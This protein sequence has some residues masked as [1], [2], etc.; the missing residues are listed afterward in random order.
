M[1]ADRQIDEEVL[2]EE[3]WGPLDEQDDETL[4][5]IAEW[6]EEQPGPRKKQPVRTNVQEQMV[7]EARAAGQRASQSQADPVRARGLLY[8]KQTGRYTITVEEENT[9]RTGKKLLVV[10]ALVGNAVYSR[11]RHI[12]DVS[13]VDGKAKQLAFYMIEK[14][15]A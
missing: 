11:E 2:A 13:A 8:E 12:V 3:G 14:V 4:T 5:D 6:L 1:L 10:S 9:S 7:E 15:R